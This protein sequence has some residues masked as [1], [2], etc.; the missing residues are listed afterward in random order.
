M[1]DILQEI[2]R[3]IAGIDE[4]V[5]RLRAET[6]SAETERSELQ[7]AL[8]VY[9]EVTGAKPAPAKIVEAANSTAPP[10]PQR[11]SAEKKQLI[12]QLLGTSEASG[13]SPATVFKQL[14]AQNIKDIPIT[15]VRTIL[16]RMENKGHG[17]ESKDGR[18][19]LSQPA[20]EQPVF[21]MDRG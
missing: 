20:T 10:A 16:W 11:P 19:W 14:V 13:K 15:Q 1:T 6:E 2:Q 8:R 21:E 17:V 12:R 18:Y 3:R 4:R 7:I 5:N 9:T